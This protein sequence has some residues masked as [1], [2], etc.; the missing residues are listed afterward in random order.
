MDGDDA[1]QFSDLSAATRQADGGW[2]VADA[3]ASMVRAFDSGGRF[4]IT[5]GGAGSGPGEFVR[6]TQVF[7]RPDG[8]VVVWDEAA[9]RATGFDPE[10]KLADVRTFSRE[11]VAQALEPPMYPASGILASDG[12]LIVRLI[13]KTA[14]VPPGRFRQK[15]GALRVTADHSSIDTVMW[16]RDTEQLSVDLPKGALALTPPLARR[17]SIAVQ[18]NEA[19]VCIGDQERAEVTCFGP[20]GLA[21]LVRWGG[22]PATVESSD[23]AVT[24][25]RDSMTDL[26]AQKMSRE[27]AGRILS[28]VPAPTERP[29]YTDLALDRD[30]NLWVK[31]G[32]ASEG[33]ASDT[34]LVFNSAG[35]PVAGPVSVPPVRILEIGADYMVGVA[36]DEFEV[37]YLQVFE[38]A[39]SHPQ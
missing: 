31:T 16:F 1:Y 32:A 20:D 18:P 8:S 3:G 4:R 24:S 34:Y 7:S 14:D 36:R 22:S 27:D 2:V 12:D 23:P 5:L 11:R 15:S 28:Q 13:V 10:G 9:F 30:G 38:I 25:W 26:Y 6:P 17:T 19:R 39:K 29:P 37:Q 33:A 21:V 35:L